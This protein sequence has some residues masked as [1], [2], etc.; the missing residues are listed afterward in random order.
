VDVESEA[1]QLVELCQCGDRKLRPT[2]AE[3][4]DMLASMAGENPLAGSLF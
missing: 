1:D 4:A 2:A 3:V